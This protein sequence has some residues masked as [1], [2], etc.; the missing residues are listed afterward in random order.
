MTNI[1]INKILE[2]NDGNFI[3]LERITLDE[4]T[5][6]EIRLATFLAINKRI[7]K[8]PMQEIHPEVESNNQEI[9]KK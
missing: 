2:S 4:R 3:T 5:P 6:E 9:I 8:S 1:K 7:E